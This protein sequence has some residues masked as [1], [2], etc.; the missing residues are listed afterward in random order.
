MAC[1][2]RVSPWTS[3][4]CVR[5]LEHAGVADPSY[6][7]VVAAAQV[8]RTLVSR[9]RQR[10]IACCVAEGDAVEYAEAHGASFILTI[11]P[12]L[13]ISEVGSA[14]RSEAVVTAA[15]DEQADQVAAFVR[16]PG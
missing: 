9:L 12:A 8:P 15:M 11:D 10:D 1:A 4:I 13:R 2:R 6:P 16:R 7:R 5:A 14:G 3:T